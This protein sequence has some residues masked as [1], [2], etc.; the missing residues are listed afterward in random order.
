ME[1]QENKPVL[2]F[3]GDCGFCRK[4]IARWQKATGNKV[5]YAPYQKVAS[6]YPQIPMDRFERAVQLVEGD[7]K[8][9]SAAA[10]VFRSLSYAGKRRAVLWW[11]YRK[12]PGFRFMSE[13]A[14]ACVARHRVLFSR[15]TSW[16]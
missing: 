16:F 6:R 1:D 9:Y 4:W 10:A 12:I 15:L 8:V 7:G 11:A 14:Y 2:I 13:I 5:S 3:D